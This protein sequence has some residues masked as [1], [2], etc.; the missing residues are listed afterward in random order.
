M[1]PQYHIAIDGNEANVTHRVGSNVYAFE[2]INT[3]SE[4]VRNDRRFQVTVLLSSRPVKDLPRTRKWWRYQVV[5]PR[6]FW[7]QWALPIHLFLEANRYDVLFTPG[8]YAPRISSVPY[9]SSVMDLA[10]LEF[11]DQFN[12]RDLVQLK[13]WTGYSVKHAQK[14]VAISEYTKQDVIK[15]YGRKAS[16]VIVAP[17]AVTPPSFTPSAKDGAQVAKKFG[18]T[19]PYIIHIGTFQPRKNV[20]RL[21]EAFEQVCRRIATNSLKHQPKR[22]QLVLVGKIGWLAEPIMD[23]IKQSPFASQIITTGYVSEEEK[24]TLLKF[25]QCS[26]HIGLYEG[27][28]IPALESLHMGTI[29]IVSNQTSLPEVVGEAGILVNPYDSTAIAKGIEYTLSLRARDR[30]KLRKT[31]RAQ[32]QRFNWQKSAEAVLQMLLDIIEHSSKKR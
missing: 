30:A 29:P 9:A 19:D 10:F 1:E 12:K 14:V 22:Y 4:L 28:G 24:V 32:V 13:S 16:D 15:H 31:G 27:F 21:I 3:L 5:K 20:L 8:H 23:R 26:A 17:P 11:T 18:I 25:A 6:Q 2:L 7:T